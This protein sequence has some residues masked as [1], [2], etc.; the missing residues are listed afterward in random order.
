M[1]FAEGMRLYS[2]AW[3]MGRLASE[4]LQAGGYDIAEGSVILFSP[5]W[6]HRDPQ[7]WDQPEKFHPERFSPEAKAARVPFSYFPFGGGPR[8]CIGEGFAWMEGVLV[9]ATLAQAWRF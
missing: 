1:A 8:G 6:A 2:P 9:L 5:Y 7:Y 4:P 3:V